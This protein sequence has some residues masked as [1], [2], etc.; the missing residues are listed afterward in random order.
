MFGYA[1]SAFILTLWGSK[2]LDVT[3]N[4]S[5]DNISLILMSMAF[6]WTVG[7][8]FYGYL[9]KK[10]KN[11][12]FIVILSSIIISLFLTILSFSY[13]YNLITL[14]IIFSLFG[15]FGA[16]SLI[17]IAHYR[18]L[19]EE[20]VIGK[21]LTTANLFNFA[22]V[23]FV[24]WITGLIIFYTNEKLKLS[25]QFSFSLAFWTVVYLLRLRI[26]PSHTYIQ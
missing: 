15:F 21:V 23:F 6:F 5:M 16:Y 14:F 4:I 2:Y 22:G 26:K 24:Q 25:Y 1:S 12:K 18:I 7:S 3:Q 11:K 19:F 17:V 20:H 13:N 9:E 8:V 10:I